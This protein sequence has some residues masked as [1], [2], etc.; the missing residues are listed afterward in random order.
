MCWNSRFCTSKP[1]KF[2]SR[3]IWVIEKSWNFHTVLTNLFICRYAKLGGCIAIKFLFERMDLRWVFQHQFS[4]LK[5]RFLKAN[6]DF[7]HFWTF[8]PKTRCQI[9]WKQHMSKY[10]KCKIMFLWPIWNEHNFLLVKFDWLKVG[11]GQNS[12]RGV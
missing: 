8:P 9:T 3:K 11:K 10:P 12:T 7:N 4:F 5:V 6:G 1:Q 2:I